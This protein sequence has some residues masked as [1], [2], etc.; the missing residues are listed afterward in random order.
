[1]YSIES[2]IGVARRRIVRL[3]E[4]KLRGLVG[5]LFHEGSKLA[6]IG[7][8]RV[9]VLGERQELVEKGGRRSCEEHRGMNH[10]HVLQGPALEPKFE[11]DPTRAALG[12]GC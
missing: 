11:P 7:F 1:M 6:G 2:R 9:H 12:I 4:M 10:R 3:K 5:M 8:A